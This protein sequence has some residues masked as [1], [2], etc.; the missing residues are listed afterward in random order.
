MG[1]GGG[2]GEVSKGCW[3]GREKV[4]GAQIVKKG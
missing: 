4:R 1:E 2:K 3:V